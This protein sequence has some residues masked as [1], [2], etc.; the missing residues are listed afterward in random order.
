MKKGLIFC[1]KVVIVDNSNTG[2]PLEG[3]R[4]SNGVHEF[5]EVREGLK[6]KTE[7]L[8]IASLAHPSFFAC[9]KTIFG[10][11]GT[12]GAE[13]EREEVQ[14]VYGTTCFEVPTHK[15]RQLVQ[16]PS[17]IVREDEDYVSF[18]IGHVQERTKLGRPV[19]IICI[20]INDS[21]EYTQQ[22]RTAGLQ[23]QVL[24]SIQAESEK[25]ILL[26]A[27]E[28]GMV[29]VA[30]N[31]AGRGTDIR[32][33]EEVVAIGGLHVVMTFLPQNL[34]VEEQGMGRSGRQGQPGTA[35]I[36]IDAKNDE[37]CRNFGGIMEVQQL[38]EFREVKVREESARRKRQA[39]IERARFSYLQAFVKRLAELELTEKEQIVPHA[40]EDA[41]ELFQYLIRRGYGKKEQ[42]VDEDAGLRSAIRGK[43][44]SEWPKFFTIICEN[45]IDEEEM[46]LEFKR[47]MDLWISANWR[48]F[49]SYFLICE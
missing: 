26:R 16:E 3:S 10:V 15:L 43:L 13:A 47:W 19:L 35:I 37:I 39:L 49:L 21:T 17:I 4:W 9:Y 45:D 28:P 41:S 42:Q 20:S 38:M 12:L 33:R 30:T 27:G 44:L 5:V 31:A 46:K 40:V 14:K 1:L 23:V 8:T 36:I 22:M 29:T 18:L 34:R 7:S 32:L 6:P 25:M 48:V 2:H 24:N 11:S